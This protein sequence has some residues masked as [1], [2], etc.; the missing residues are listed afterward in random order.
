MKCRAFAYSLHHRVVAGRGKY[1]LIA[2]NFMP[3]INSFRANE[4]NDRNTDGFKI[5][6]M[7]LN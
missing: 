2:F 6:E 7:D 5:L 3:K 4:S 1:Q